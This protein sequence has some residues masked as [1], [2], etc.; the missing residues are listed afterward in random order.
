MTLLP[1]PITPSTAL[2]DCLSH[3]RDAI[4][5]TLPPNGT[6]PRAV[7]DE[8]V[9]FFSFHYDVAH[10]NILAFM[11]LT[12]SRDDSTDATLALDH[13]KRLRS[14]AVAAT[15]TAAPTPSGW[16]PRKRT[17]GSVLLCLLVVPPASSPPPWRL[18]GR[19][20]VDLTLTLTLTLRVNPHRTLETLA[21]K[22]L[23]GWHINVRK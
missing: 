21:D 4:S 18:R 9:A 6:S 14:P 1:P 10:G 3:H 19:P 17:H 7:I 16:L 2:R 20:N 11:P 15:S 13:Q 12:P 22:I 8:G 23:A 5:T